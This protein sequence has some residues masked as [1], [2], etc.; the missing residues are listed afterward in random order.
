MA[1]DHAARIDLKSPDSPF[2]PRLLPRF[3]PKPFDSSDMCRLQ[4]GVERRHKSPAGS[5]HAAR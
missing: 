4:M 3:L 5:L 2:T 1:Y